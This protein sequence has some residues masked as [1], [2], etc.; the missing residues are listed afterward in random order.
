MTAVAIGISSEN[1]YSDM[2]SLFTWT[3]EQDSFVSQ[4]RRSAIMRRDEHD[5]KTSSFCALLTLVTTRRCQG[6]RTV[7]K[8]VAHAKA[9]HPDDGTLFLQ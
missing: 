1:D 6:Q 3:L 5:G 2:N 9:V 7:V 8:G 4:M